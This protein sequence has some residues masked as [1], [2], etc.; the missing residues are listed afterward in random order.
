MRLMQL[1]LPIRAA[2]RPTVTLAATTTAAAPL[3]PP[4]SIVAANAAVEG[5]RFAS[6]KAQGAYKLKNKKTLPKKMGAK[7]VGDQYVLPGTIIYKQR[8]TLWFPGEN[9]ILGRDHTI[10]AAVA[11]YV[12]Y[13][14]DPQ[15]HPD[16]QYIGITFERNDTLPYSPNAPRKRRLGLVAVP[17][18]AAPEFE[19]LTRSGIPRRVIRKA[20]IIEVG[21]ATEEA[22][23][24]ETAAAKAAEAVQAADAAADAAAAPSSQKKETKATR[25]ARRWNAYIRIKRTNRVLYVNKNYAYRESNFMIGRLMG[26]NNGTR[27]YGSRSAVLRHRRT[28]R[29][30][31]LRL[32]KEL[33]AQQRMLSSDK[34]A[35]NTGGKKKAKAAAT[36]KKTGPRK[37]VA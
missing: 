30:E 6:V 4:H 23:K 10:H 24:G 22:T 28:K 14:R 9:T 37:R 18:K 29:D 33:L 16:R 35:K 34:S 12:K 5:H 3:I 25:A 36:K 15:R 8:G 13:Y 31:Q 19:P 32:R 2:V 27:R 20:G 1:R 11:G 26:K 21:E 17:L 7:R